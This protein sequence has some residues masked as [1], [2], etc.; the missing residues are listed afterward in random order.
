MY[1]YISYTLLTFLLL[2]V[3]TSAN[4]QDAS[5]KVILIEGEATEVNVTNSGDILEVFR[6]LPGYMSGF[7]PYG[8]QARNDANPVYPNNQLIQEVEIAEKGA[9]NYNIFFN[10]GKDVVDENGLV[11]LDKA[12]EAYKKRQSAYILIEGTYKKG[13]RASQKLADSRVGACKEYLNSS[14]IAS[15]KLVIS[16][17][18][19][20]ASSNNIQV[21]IR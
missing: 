8:G 12:I 11:K 1:R 9:S 14:E 2:M 19:A 18:E 13:D 7:I 5:K 10:E 17:N 16:L 6:R 20:S 4:G 15:S 21:K 3:F